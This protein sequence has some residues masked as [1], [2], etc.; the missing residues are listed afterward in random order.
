MLLLSCFVW[1]MC[2]VEVVP[3]CRQAV[4][5]AKLVHEPQHTVCQELASI[6]GTHIG[7]I[8]TC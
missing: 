8:S 3:E 4:G 7:R 1:R 2:D 6:L 5:D